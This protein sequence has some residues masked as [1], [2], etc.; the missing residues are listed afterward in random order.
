MGCFRG[1]DQYDPRETE[2]V[3]SSP[4]CGGVGALAEDFDD[5]TL[6]RRFWVDENGSATLQ[7]GQL[8]L[9]LPADQGACS[10][11]GS[12]HA[13]DLTGRAL[14]LELVSLAAPAAD[15]AFRFWV[16]G[17]AGKG[18]E[19]T[20]DDEMVQYIA[21]D[22]ESFSTLAS[23]RYD[24]TLHRFLRIREASGTVYWETSSDGTEWTERAKK[25]TAELFDIRYV[26]FEIAG[27]NSGNGTAGE[28][29]VDNLIGGGAA[30]EEICPCEALRDDFDDGSTAAAWDGP[31]EQ[32]GC[33]M[34]ETGGELQ[35]TVPPQEYAECAY[36][37]R[38]AY[39]LRGGTLT[40]ELTGPPDLADDGS[41]QLS[42][43]SD[44]KHQLYAH[45]KQGELYCT[46][47]TPDQCLDLSYSQ[48]SPTEQRWL[49]FREDGGTVYFETSPDGS[50]WDVVTSTI[51]P[52]AV[53][54]VRVKLSA[55][56]Y[57]GQTTPMEVRLDNLNVLP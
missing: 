31:H 33:T 40:V 3:G 19:I 10:H 56:V 55:T 54:M 11:F 48:H 24:A 43:M 30:T 13:Y 42:L 45:V 39:D 23:Q 2:G 7:D 50:T 46:Q 37:S 5:G 1:W 15:A 41:V 12:H 27:Q 44:Q 21:Q 25:P 49:R 18:L 8:V 9:W 17:P 34:A 22:G 35:I 36:V 28:F 52:F 29:R 32:S 51:E 20:I 53:D 38:S 4:L 57:G 47:A 16:H 14:G 26:S 6:D